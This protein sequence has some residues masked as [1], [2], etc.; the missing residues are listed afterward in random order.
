MALASQ[1]Q[2]TGA[3]REPGGRIATGKTV[4][5]EG[6]AGRKKRVFLEKKRV[7]GT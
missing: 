6:G 3:R 7:S 1:S 5:G 2:K 4:A